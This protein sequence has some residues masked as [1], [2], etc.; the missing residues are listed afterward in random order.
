ME[1]HTENASELGI[2]EG[3]WVIVESP[4]GSAKF[5]ARV[6]DDILKGVVN[7]DHGWGGDSNVNFLTDDRDLDPISGFPAFR[8]GLCRVR[9][10]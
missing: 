7:M 5:K 9:K 3:D 8:Q 6:T 2:M 10:A 4:R 1:I